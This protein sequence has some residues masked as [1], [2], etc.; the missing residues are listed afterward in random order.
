M[1]NI[2]KVIYGGEVLID[3][4]SDSVTPDKLLAP[5]TAHDKAGNLITGTCTFN[6]DT[7]DATATRDEILNNKVAYVNGQRYVGTMPY[8]NVGD[9]DYD[10]GDKIIGFAITNFEQKVAIPKGYTDGSQ[11][12]FIERV[13]RAKFSPANIR[14]GVTLLGVT[15]TMTGSEDFNQPQQKVVTPSKSAQVIV[16][17]TGYTHL[18]QVTV[19]AIPID[20]TQNSAGGITVTIL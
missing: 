11:Y 7:R 8:S 1:A 2:S 13:E 20:R 19:H 16:P 5:E 17:D 15:G 9:E 6:A 10:G 4:T 18:T 14:E 3:L 12:V